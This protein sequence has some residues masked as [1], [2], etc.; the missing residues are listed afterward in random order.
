MLLT[1]SKSM[2]YRKRLMNWIRICRRL[3]SIS[4]N[5]AYYQTTRTKWVI[6]NRW[7]KFIAIE[8]LNPTPGLVPLLKRK[9]K[10]IPDFDATLQRD[11]FEKSVYIDNSRL[12]HTTSEF[13]TLFSRWKMLTQ[14]ETLFRVL[15]EKARLMHKLQLLQKCFWAMRTGLSTSDYAK[16]IREDTPI[17]SLV[18]AR[19]DIEQLV[20]R[21]INIRRKSITT[22]VRRNNRKY[23]KYVIKEGQ[24]ALS[25]KSFMADFTAATNSRIST[26]QRMI[27]DYFEERGTQQFSDIWAPERDHAIVPQIMAKV[28]GRQ[29]ADPHTITADGRSIAVPGGYK[30]SR[31]KFAF[32]YGV[33]I[34]GWQLFWNADGGRELESPQRGSWTSASL[35]NND[36]V[37]PKEDF[38]V[39][40]EYLYDS[41]VIVGV[42]LKLLFGGFTRWIGGK[43]SLS[44]L[45]VYMD[46]ENCSQREEYEDVRDSTLDP[47]E[48]ANP[49][50]PYNFVIGLTGVVTAGRTTCL[51]LVIRK[52]TKQNLFSYTWVG[53]ALW[54]SELEKSEAAAEM[55]LPSID[56][57]SMP[58]HLSNFVAGPPVGAPMVDGG[59]SLTM[60]HALSS[61]ADEGGGDYQKVEQDNAS[62][63]SLE[64]SFPGSS[65]VHDDDESIDSQSQDPSQATGLSKGDAPPP[66][67]RARR[68]GVSNPVVAKLLNAPPPTAKEAL[69]SSEVQFFD[70]LRMRTTELS[71]ARSRATEFARNL[72]TNKLLRLDNELG[73]LVVIRIVR[74]LTLWLF[75][76]LSKRMMPLSHTE[77]PAL[78]LLRNAKML[79]SKADSVRNR[80]NQ[81][82][83][84]AD[85]LES[86]AQ[87]WTGKHLLSPKERA[88]KAEHH[89]KIAALRAEAAKVRRDENLLRLQAVIDE[90]RGMAQ[91]PRLPLSQY[92][93]NNYRLKLAAARHKESLLERMTLDD[94][95]NG[96]FGTNLKEKLLSKEQMQAIHESLRSQQ[97]KLKDVT[98]LDRLIDTVVEEEGEIAAGLE[99]RS[100]ALPP[101]NLR[102][103]TLSAAPS[104]QRTRLETH[105]QQQPPR[106]QNRKLSEG[107]AL[108]LNSASLVNHRS[109]TPLVMTDRIGSPE[110][111][112]SR[113]G[114]PSQQ[115]Q[116]RSYS[117]MEFNPLILPDSG[118]TGPPSPTA[119]QRRRTSPNRRVTASTQQAASAGQPARAN[120]MLNGRRASPP[121]GRQLVTFS[122]LSDEL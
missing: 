85:V 102:Q 24:T 116:G 69:S 27:S 33:G 78:K 121:K 46:C 4:R 65:T 48:L 54:K 98:S 86:S 62:V 89:R 68:M 28:T 97:L 94:V 45:G 37:I 47:D 110:F 113:E 12:Q 84:S 71:H 88:L 99:K 35:G 87:L 61:T 80:V 111:P 8:K 63:D 103:T 21:F 66:K 75:N 39:G 64:E 49:A 32:Q 55:T 2:Y 43:T 59:D 104:L 10:L 6:F 122:E 101:K 5:A 30:L 26:E 117:I 41:D 11:G 90:K 93:V 106:H 42:R 60:S 92:V 22:V 51:G 7:L 34:I 118:P 53:D 108:R 20:K 1:R 19:A 67:P 23:V 70:V 74:G 91:M 29:F 100:I 83:M 31:I 76:A 16:L 17:F 18:R 57:Y 44:T 107:A 9:A 13:K 77:K 95:K 115:G 120:T 112:G 15:S 82:L 81:I 14:E 114:P 40:L 25:F 72:W 73:K 50:M 119:Q 56:M 109:R 36:F 58:T 52:V 105:I 38:V 96:L 3:N 79:I